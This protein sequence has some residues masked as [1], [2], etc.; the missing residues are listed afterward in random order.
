MEENIENMDIYKYIL[1]QI[2]FFYQRKNH[3]EKEKELEDC[4]F[5]KI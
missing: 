1:N 4:F 5:L 2:M 3:Q